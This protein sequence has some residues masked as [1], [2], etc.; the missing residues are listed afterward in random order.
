[1]NSKWTISRKSVQLGIIALITAPLCGLNFFQGNLSAATLFGVCLA[2]PISFLQATLASH[3]FV[4]S[5]FVSA[6]IVTIFYVVVGG[7][8]FCG[9]VCPVYLITE[10]GDYVRQ[11]LETG[12]RL[13]PLRGVR[14]SLVLTLLVSLVA[15]IPV[16]EVVSPIGVT[17]RAIMFTSLLPL[18]LVGAILIVEI[19]FARRVW[20]RSLCPVGGFYSLLGQISPVRIH[21]NKGACTDCGECSLVCPV[22]EVLVQP[23]VDGALQVNSGDCTRCGACIDVCGSKALGIGIGYETTKN[24]GGST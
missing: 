15:G 19:F 23:L 13:Y 2:D 8:S 22:E 21:F 7:R 24:S 12:E 6:M 4:P 16:F 3:V 20:C 11:R 14:V 10:L 1:M 5:F 9:W 18:L 17:A